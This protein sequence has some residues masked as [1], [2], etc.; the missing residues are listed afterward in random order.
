MLDW[1]LDKS[2]YRREYGPQLHFDGAIAEPWTCFGASGVRDKC[3][4]K[5]QIVPGLWNDAH[6]IMGFR[7][8]GL[9]MMFKWMVADVILSVEEGIV[10]C[11]AFIIQG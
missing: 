11:N 1:C 7:R 6:P 3:S 2:I 8:I 5:L 10:A 9:W 4:V